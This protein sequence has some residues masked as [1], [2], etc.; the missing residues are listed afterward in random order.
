MMSR[1]FLNALLCHWFPRYK[2]WRICQAIGIKPYTWQKEFALHERVQFPSGRCTGK[3]MAV[4][5]RLLMLKPYDTTSVY[6]VLC[7]D[8]D[9]RGSDMKRRRW[10]EGEYRRRAAECFQA[11]IPVNINVFRQRR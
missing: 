7:C 8:P 6:S 10:Y 4:M 2:L 9:W 11:G 1:G 5:L 3:T